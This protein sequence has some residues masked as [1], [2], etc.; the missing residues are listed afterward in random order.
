VGATRSPAS[1]LASLVTD[2]SGELARL[3]TS[4]PAAPERPAPTPESDGSAGRWGIA[5]VIL[6]VIVGVIVVAGV[7]SKQTGTYGG[8]STDYAA[9]TPAPAAQDDASLY[10]SEA[11][12]PPPVQT[13]VES[14]PTGTQA[15]PLNADQIAYCLAE[16]ARILAS[17]SNA[18]ASGEAASFNAYVS[19]YNAV[20]GSFTYAQADFE[21]ASAY[22][23]GR[24]A[25]LAQE[26][27][28]RFAFRDASASFTPPAAPQAEDAE[29]ASPEDQPPVAPAA[30]T[31]ESSADPG[32]DSNP[33]P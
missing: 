1:V 6:A 2:I 14:A 11:S 9:S 33:P 17:E 26:G 4:A 25:E 18:Q 32:P 30:A 24:S 7:S 15:G 8:S 13:I 21:R 31:P 23:A 27:A 28:Q 10:S 29:S 12:A 16:K 20:C 5:G 22:V 3:E 19:R